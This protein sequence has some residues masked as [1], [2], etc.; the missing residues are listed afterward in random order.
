M[1]TLALLGLAVCPAILI[2]QTPSPRYLSRDSWATPFVEHLVRSGVLRGL[3]PLTRPFERHDVAQALAAV[4]TLPL[5]AS[6]R[7][8]IRQ[9]DQEFAEPSDT[10][11]WSLEA[12]AGMLAGSDARRW[13]LRP[14]AD[15][16]GF[17]PEGGLAG[18]VEF[19]HVALVTH[20]LINNRLRYDP[21][22]TGKKDRIIAGRNDEAYLHASWRYAAVFFG[23]MDRNWGPPEVEGLLLS[24]S[25]YS[26]DH[27]MVRLGARRFRIELLATQLDEVPFWDSSERAK[28]YLSVHRVSVAPSPR[29]SFA[30][31]EAALYATSG[32]VTRSFEPWY[33]NPL[34]LWLLAQT[35]GVLTANALLAG[36]FSWLVRGNLRLAG[37]L[38]VDDIQIDRKTQADREP[39][40]YGYTLSLTGGAAHGV[41]SWSGLYTRVTNTAYRTPANEEQYTLRSVGLA[42]NFA[43]YDQAT[44]RAT[45]VPRP[46]TLVGVETTLLRQGEGDMRT[47]FPP[48]SAY[49]DS[50]TFLTGVVERTVRVAA[51]GDWLPRDGIRFSVDV[52]RHFLDNA[53]HVSGVTAGR[54]VWRVQAEVRRH[55][56]GALRW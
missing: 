49:A 22:Y 43:D 2:A 50:L 56:G 41:V 8:A 54:W 5:G 39:P 1:R 24:P 13:A 14:S 10:V 11:R 36:E 48:V 6:L 12:H 4:D 28:R 3:D 52:G 25:P 15:S 32:G 7:S 46:R 40:G 17:Y 16:A 18:A 42:R 47:R 55:W 35:D 37:Q 21:D 44:L 19:P 31:S 30:L 27:L 33:L 9:L 38:Y 34:N 20:P 23:S 29:L 53:G 26:Y 51:Q 45:A